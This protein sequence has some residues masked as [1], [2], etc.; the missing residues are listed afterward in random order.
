[1]NAAEKARIAREKKEAEER[2]LREQK[3][4]EKEEK[5]KER[6]KKRIGFLKVL[7]KVLSITFGVLTFLVGFAI[8]CTFTEDMELTLV[9]NIVNA[10]L[11]VL[12]IIFIVINV[13]WDKLDK[14]KDAPGDEILLGVAL[15][16]GGSLLLLALI[17]GLGSIL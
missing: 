6:E 12:D 3:E 8:L 4:K 1:M 2:V 13:K 15:C 9:L 14:R 17:I 16:V 11:V 10:I 5:A 7:V